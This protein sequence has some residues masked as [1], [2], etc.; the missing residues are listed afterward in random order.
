MLPRHRTLRETIDWSHRLL[1]ESEAVLFRRLS[2]FA[3]SVSLEAAEAVCAQAAGVS[4]VDPD[5][6]LDLL[7][8][9]VDKSLVGME[10]R[11]GEARYR[12]LET[13][14]QYAYRRLEEAEEI[15][16][17]RAAHAEWFV[18]L[19]EE[20]E[21]RIFGGASDPARLLRLT[22]EEGNLRAALD[23]S[24]ADPRRA[25][26]GLRIGAA[27]HW[28][29]FA[30]GR[31]DEG[32][33][34]LDRALGCGVGVL[35][36]V[37]ARALTALGTA[38]I[39][40][41]DMPAARAPMEEAVAILRA[42]GEP[43]SPAEV[44][45]L[46]YALSGLGAALALA[47]EPDP[48]AGLLEESCV[49][50]RR[51]EP[52]VLTAFVLYWRGMAA[53]ARDDRR[54]ARA[55]LEESLEVGRGLGGGPAVAH[56]LTVLG[57]IALAPGCVGEARERLGEALDLHREA[58]GP[59]GRRAGD[60]GV[61]RALR[62]RPD[63]RS[64]G[65]GCSARIDALRGGHRHAATE[66][67]AGGL[68]SA[69]RRDALGAGRGRLRPRPRR[70][71]FGVQRRRGGGARAGRGAATSAEAP[72]FPVRGHRAVLRAASV[73]C[74][75]RSRGLRGSSAA[76]RGCPPRDPC[77]RAVRSPPSRASP[78]LR[79]AAAA[80]ASCWSS[81]PA[82]RMAVSKDQARPCALAQASPSQVRNLFHVTLHRLRKAL[83]HPDWIVADGEG[84]RLAPGLG[85]ELDA[86]RFE[87]EAGAALREL[88]KGSE[89]DRPAAIDR[90]AEASRSTAATC[91]RPRRSASG[92]STRAAG[93]RQ[94]FL[95]GLRALGDAL[96]ESERHA[97][98]AEVFRRLLARDDL[99]EA[100]HRRLLLALGRAGG[101]KGVERAYRRLVD[102]LR[103]ELDV[104]PEPETA[105]LYER[106]RRAR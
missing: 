21:P 58:G 47:G 29:W 32:R 46:A 99:D 95:E 37:R 63:G 56:P 78:P 3:G 54:L 48:A 90:L 11:D 82:T 24:E 26:V 92:T 77:A 70:G 98:A 20:A 96:D 93:S 87:A 36:R 80:R 101:R 34:R 88:R 51:L 72:R 28:A 53:L 64:T 10:V 50:A 41:G 45:D 49:L 69:D 66:P 102:L 100:T 7:A 61:G 27:I 16:A 40:Q 35:P 85:F 89:A 17:L 71:T 25:E 79:A 8:S 12:L 74:R 52:R 31:F 23:W 22:E 76:G 6:V 73:R 62:S 84:Y 97:E 55:S 91:S 68:R 65:P 1:D 60:R 81:S 59:V 15:E 13:V 5:A 43:C 44:V 86:A 19:A 39:W 2:V 30:W 42:E 33:R 83:G 9:L 106:L 105:A 67:V 57:R 103:R 14:R 104:E 94:L 4:P 75:S 38:A 18:A